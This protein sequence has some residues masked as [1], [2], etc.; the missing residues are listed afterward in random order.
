MVISTIAH[1]QV[2]VHLGILLCACLGWGKGRHGEMVA[3]LGLGPFLPCTSATRS[4][5]S[6]AQ[7]GV[8][9]QRPKPST[10][11]IG[12]GQRRSLASSK[13]HSAPKMVKGNAGISRFHT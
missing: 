1:P 13:S 10:P 3:E 8:G 4:A 5:L 11:P 7:M 2:V 12:G 9:R 6:I